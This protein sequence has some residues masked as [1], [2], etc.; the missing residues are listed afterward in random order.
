MQSYINNFM[1]SPPTL[2]ILPFEEDN[3]QTRC[4]DGKNG[5]MNLNMKANGIVRKVSERNVRQILQG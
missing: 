4:Y 1:G 5:N 2:I 3:M